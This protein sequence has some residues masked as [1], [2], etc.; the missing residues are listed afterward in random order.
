[1][2]EGISKLTQKAGE[3]RKESGRK[4]GELMRPINRESFILTG[5]Y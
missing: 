5:I 2:D 1:M 4:W 3:A